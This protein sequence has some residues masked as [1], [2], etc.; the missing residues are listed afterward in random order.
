MKTLLSILLVLA[1][2][3]PVVAEDHYGEICDG[4]GKCSPLVLGGEPSI[5]YLCANDVCMDEDELYQAA[6]KAG[7]FCE[8]KGHQW[9][10]EWE[11]FNFK[12][13]WNPRTAK[14]EHP[15]RIILK[16]KLCDRVEYPYGT[17]PR[18]K[19]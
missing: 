9:E 13:I 4:L 11:P 3:R 18:L 10:E 7:I 19:D 16:C 6:I 12:R 5:K 2:C 15:G 17:A 14:Y 1:L 8:R